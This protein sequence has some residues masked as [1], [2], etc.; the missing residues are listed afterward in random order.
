M[1]KAGS[2]VL[3]KEKDEVGKE[4]DE[5]EKV[6]SKIR[7]VC[8]CLCF[9]LYRKRRK[10]VNWKELLIKCITLNIFLISACFMHTHCLPL[11][12]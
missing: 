3:R 12:K 5:V 9:P 11:E 10:I 4:K 1:K 6:V 8:M 7:C 2:T